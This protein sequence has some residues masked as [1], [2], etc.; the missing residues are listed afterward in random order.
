MCGIMP[1][2]SASCF[3]SAKSELGG[4][5]RSAIRHGRAGVV[6]RCSA[7]SVPAELDWP[8]APEIARVGGEGQEFP[9][10]GHEKVTNISDERPAPGGRS[11]E[12]SVGRTEH[13][14]SAPRLSPVG[15]RRRGK[16]AQFVGYSPHRSMF[17][18]LITAL[19]VR[20]VRQSISRMSFP[21]A[22]VWRLHV[23]CASR[24]VRCVGIPDL[25]S[26]PRS[27]G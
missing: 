25:L 8:T 22:L 3:K 1:L 21:V 23:D 24:P 6:R 20:A 26:R 13:R 18:R 4:P 16:S 9:R 15:S 27:A 12:H 11:G 19:T 14:R 7:G 2:L 10:F 17:P 5:C